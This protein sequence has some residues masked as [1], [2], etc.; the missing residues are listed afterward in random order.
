[1][2]LISASFGMFNS[3]RERFFFELPVEIGE[4]DLATGDGPSHAKTSTINFSFDCRLLM[5][6][7]QKFFDEPPDCETRLPGIFF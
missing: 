2:S 4:C 6:F 3:R 5:R 1:M 7:V